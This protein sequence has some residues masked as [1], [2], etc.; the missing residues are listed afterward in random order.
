M[1]MITKTMQ[2]DGGLENF[3]NVLANKPQ[4]LTALHRHI[5]YTSHIYPLSRDDLAHVHGLGR[6]LH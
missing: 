5:F 4:I 6:P 2:N 3:A 1:G